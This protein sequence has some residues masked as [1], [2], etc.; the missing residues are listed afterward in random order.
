M[1][2]DESIDRTID[3]VAR[4]MT[5]ATTPALEARVAAR[6]RPRSSRRASWLVPAA[7]MLATASVA[8]FVVIQSRPLAIRPPAVASPAALQSSV[9]PRVSPPEVQRTDV[10]RPA[11]ERVGR[12]TI[13]DSEA[14]G[15]KERAVPA[16]EAV[17]DLTM[18]AIQPMAPPIAQ[19]WVAPIAP[20]P[21]LVVRAIGSDR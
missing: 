3:E 7:V 17:P 8:L 14:T 16:L 12:T 2:F 21:P 4:A 13:A 1:H 6:L 19:L 11:T 20:T 10:Q 18:P 9:I 15:W 5:A